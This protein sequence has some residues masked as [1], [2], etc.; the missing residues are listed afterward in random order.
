LA[1]LARH[2]EQTVK[3]PDLAWWQLWRA[4][5]SEERFVVGLGAGLVSGIGF[6]LGVG[7]AFGLWAGLG[8]GS[9]IGFMVGTLFASGESNAVPSRR[10]RPRIGRIAAGLGAGLVCGLVLWLAA[11]LVYGLGAGL[12]FGL[13]SGIAFGLKS[14]PLTEAASPAV[15]LGRDRRTALVLLSLV[16]LAA[17]VLFGIIVLPK[18]GSAFTVVLA[19]EVVVLLPL[20]WLMRLVVV[21]Y[22]TAWPTYIGARCWLAL[23]HRLPWPLMAFLDDAHQRGILRQ[24]GSVFQFR[25]IDLQ[26]RLASH[27]GQHL[28][29]ASAKPRDIEPKTRPQGS[30]L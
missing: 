26:R 29:S 20:L 19:A 1:F 12:M 10:L 22:L 24:V 17:G 30:A 7:L 13:M 16:P 27:A 11:G 28:L 4:T 18:R 5:R 15:V 14:E 23:N 25:H 8:F 21:K 9:W 2:L 6:G 3:G